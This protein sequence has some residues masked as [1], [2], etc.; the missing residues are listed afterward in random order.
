MDENK[1]KTGIER[2]SRKRKPQ[3]VRL[4]SETFERCKNL[5]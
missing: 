2:E 4:I 1:K 3:S 5:M